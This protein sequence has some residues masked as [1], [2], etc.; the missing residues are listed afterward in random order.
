MREGEGRKSDKVIRQGG[1][2]MQPCVCVCAC[3]CVCV[4]VHACVLACACVC[5]V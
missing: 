4:R 2:G 1:V 3:V 5:E